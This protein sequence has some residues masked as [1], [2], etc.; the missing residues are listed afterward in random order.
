[1]F[2][3]LIE[4]VRYCIEGAAEDHAARKAEIMRKAQDRRNVRA[5]K[6][7]SVDVAKKAKAASD[8]KSAA[9]KARRAENSKMN[10]AAARKRRKQCSCGE[11][12]VHG[13]RVCSTC[14]PA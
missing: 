12:F 13:I 7:T 14:G 4:G 8:A 3:D 11:K 5:G 6:P 9:F 10:R 1:M 2:Q